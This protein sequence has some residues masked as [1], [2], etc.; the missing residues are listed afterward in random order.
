MLGGCLAPGR[1][2][3]PGL[4]GAG[5]G[6]GAGLGGAL[7]RGGLVPGGLCAW[8]VGV[9]SQEV[10]GGEPPLPRQLLLR[11]VRILLECIL[12]GHLSTV[13]DVLVPLMDYY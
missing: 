7:S 5:P 13:K 9:W 12:V 2:G 1:V 3:V 11:A 10:P 4:G 8:S 6:G